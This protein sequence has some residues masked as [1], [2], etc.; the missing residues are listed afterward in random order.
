MFVVSTHY[1]CHR[2]GQGA[3]GTLLR[4]FAAICRS[5]G[6]TRRS[7]RRPAI[8]DAH[9]ELRALVVKRVGRVS[10][11]LIVTS[12]G[13]HTPKT[14]G[15]QRR[16]GGAVDCAYFGRTARRTRVGQEHPSSSS[17]VGLGRRDSGGGGEDTNKSKT[18]VQSGARSHFV[19][20]GAG[21]HAIT[22]RFMHCGGAVVRAYS[23]RAARRTRAARSGSS[24]SRGAF[25]SRDGD[26]SH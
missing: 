8:G 5:L 21:G 12:P 26:K 10:C 9:A 13:R 4:G 25:L 17:L 24:S 23:G 22:Q 7:A 19:R 20:R 16:Y 18:A 1:L 14:Q 3:D 6:V 11:G 15:G 2:S